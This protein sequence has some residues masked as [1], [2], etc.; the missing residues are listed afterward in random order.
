M[1]DLLLLR[2][3]AGVLF[4]LLLGGAA[5]STRLERGGSRPYEVEAIYPVPRLLHR[6]WLV[7]NIPIPLIGLF[8]GAVW[9]VAVYQTVANLSFPGDTGLQLLGIILFFPGGYLALSSAKHLG[10]FMVVDIAVSKDHELVT[11]GPYAWIRHP[12]YTA[13]LLIALSVALLLLNVLFIL[14]FLMV[15]IIATYRALAEEKLLAS[16]KGFGDE[17]RTY[18]VRTGRFLPRVVSRRK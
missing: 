9:P 4:V 12:T 16:E 7:V 18:M 17:Y 3:G 10:R 1:L 13:A 11:T 5:I 15:A 2:I 14:N 8:L 6:V